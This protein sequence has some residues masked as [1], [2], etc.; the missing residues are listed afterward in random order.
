MI[1]VSPERTSDSLLAH[2]DH[3]TWSRPTPHITLLIM[4]L[5]RLLS[6]EGV[7]TELRSAEGVI[8]AERPW[9]LSHTSS[10]E[11]AVRLFSQLPAGE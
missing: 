9:Q 4:C 10:Q 11:V 2:S 1:Q 6:A 5:L 8:T 7:I 3:A